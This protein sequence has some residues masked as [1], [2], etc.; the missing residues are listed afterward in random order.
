MQFPPPSRH[1]EIMSN[2]SSDPAAAFSTLS[3]TLVR[4]VAKA[5]VHV[6]NL[7]WG[8]RG[9]LS[10]ILW[11]EGVLVT[12]EQSLPDAEQYD[13]VLPGGGHAKATL[14]GRDPATNVAVLR[15]EAKAAAFSVAE[16]AG[17][18]ALVLALGSDGGGGVTARM[19]GIEVMG[20]AWE[21]QRGGRIDRLVRIGVRLPQGAEG[22]PVVDASGALLGMST[23]GPGRG[24][25]V[26]PTATVGRVVDPLLQQGRMARGWL[27]VG[28]HE[29]ALPPEIAQRA[30]AAGGLMV[31]SF[32]EAAPAAGA[33]LPGDILVAVAGNAV[34]T[35]RALARLLGPEAVGKT[36]E[37]TLVRGGALTTVA[38]V[39]GARP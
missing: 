18:G 13:A 15:L 29:V 33:L 16:P 25:L 30:A 7:A 10:A 37:L 27:G 11:R 1:F 20:P 38:V 3:D 6:A 39:I 23:F 2:A 26:I 9:A 31:M 21:S 34:T 35:V 28:L 22:G 24:V 12:S 17:V 14:A 5:S 4:V 8:R 19:G 32:A 36:L